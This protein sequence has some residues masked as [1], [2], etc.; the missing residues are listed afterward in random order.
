MTMSIRSLPAFVIAGTHSGVGKT[1]VALAM[2]AALRR[3]GLKVAPFKVGPDFIDAGLHAAAAGGA[4]RNLDGWMLPRETNVACWRKNVR[5][6]DAAIV[7]GMMGLYDGQSGRGEA[8]STAEMAKW[9]GLS[10]VLVADASALARSAAAL[11]LGYRNFD[12]G[13]DVAGVIFNR[14]GGPGHAALLKDALA[15]TMLGCFGAL[16]FDARLQIPERHLGLATAAERVLTPRML[17]RLARW[18]EAHLDLDALLERARVRVALP[19]PERAAAPGRVTVAVARDRAFSFYY[20]DN[21]DALR[22]AGARLR[23][24]SPIADRRLPAGT[25]GIYFGGGYPE[26]YAREL[27]L[28]R[29]LLRA[30]RDFVAGGGP[31]YAEC[32]GLMYLSKALIDVNGRRHAMAGVYP[33]ATRMHPALR[34]IGYREVVFRR[35]G[36]L[37][38]GESARGHE[39]H[40]STLEKAA[41]QTTPRAYTRAAREEC[42]GYVHKNC[43]ASYVHLHFGSNPGFVRRFVAVCEEA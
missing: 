25:S 34:M 20:A 19:P 24:F 32:G 41:A 30:V 6:K 1:T 11:C 42:G 12:R 13:V 40:Y 43:V 29:P 3:R 21:L 38:A 18:A 5:G 14:V 9:L 39:F 7:E 2:M 37:P 33:F 22:A 15:S 23:F 17:E 10:V 35:G 26:L 28:N 4:A 27:A 31:V 8:G 16:P 36:F